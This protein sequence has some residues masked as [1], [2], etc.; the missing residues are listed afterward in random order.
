MV[1][2]AAPRSKILLTVKRACA[3]TAASAS[4]GTRGRRLGRARVQ[5]HG[6]GLLCAMCIGMAVGAGD[7]TCARSP[8]LARR[9]RRNASRLLTLLAHLHPARP[10]VALKE[11]PGRA[12]SVFC[13]GPDFAH[14][15]ELAGADR[16]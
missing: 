12:G 6:W 8:R 11:A 7:H 13:R 3:T 14:A 4:N 2:D 16:R 10:P 5:Q 1:S 15:G 9:A